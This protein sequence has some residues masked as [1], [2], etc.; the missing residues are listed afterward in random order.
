MTSVGER[1]FRCSVPISILVWLTDGYTGCRSG[2]TC[3]TQRLE[4]L[5]KRLLACQPTFFGYL[6]F[7]GCCRIAASPVCHSS[8]EITDLSSSQSGILP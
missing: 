8:R 5:R 1:L 2:M 3:P 4:L 7:W 6:D